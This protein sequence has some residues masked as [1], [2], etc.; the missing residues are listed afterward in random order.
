MGRHAGKQRLGQGNLANTLQF[1]NF[2]QNTFEANLA[3]IPFETGKRGVTI[4]VTSIAYFPF[5]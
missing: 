1:V 3:G 5:Q 2:G 4:Q